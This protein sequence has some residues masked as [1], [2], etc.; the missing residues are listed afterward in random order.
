MIS[1]M[2]TVTVH[3]A[4]IDSA[5]LDDPHNTVAL[6]STL[7]CVVEIHRVMYS[8]LAVLHQILGISGM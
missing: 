2:C 6:C 8:V 5:V 4:V 3:D 7:C 1:G